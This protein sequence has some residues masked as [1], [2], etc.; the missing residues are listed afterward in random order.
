MNVVP[1]YYTGDCTPSPRSLDPSVCCLTHRGLAVGFHLL[2]YSVVPTVESLSL[3]YLLFISWL[4]CTRR[5]FMDKICEPNIY[6]SWSTSQLRVRLVTWNIFKPSSIF[7]TDRS[8]AVPFFVGPF[9]YLSF[10]FVFA[11]LPCLF[12]AAL[13]SPAEKGLISWLFCMDICLCFC[14]FPI[15]YVRYGTWLYRFLI[16][17]FFFTLVWCMGKATPVWQLTLS[18]RCHQM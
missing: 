10:V 4:V 14:H 11:I 1:A 17:V 2:R 8:N 18:H 5:W 7:L 13:W 6:V 16:F 3:F 9:C 12:L 15:P